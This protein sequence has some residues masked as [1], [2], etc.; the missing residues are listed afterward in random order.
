M[1]IEMDYV[2]NDD[3]SD[4]LVMMNRGDKGKGVEKSN[5]NFWNE[6]MGGEYECIGNIGNLLNMFGNKSFGNEMRMDEVDWFG[7]MDINKMCGGFMR[8]FKL[9][10]GKFVWDDLVV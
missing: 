9:K 1:K 4:R 10:R 6:I 5:N 2:W 8:C 7:W 3:G